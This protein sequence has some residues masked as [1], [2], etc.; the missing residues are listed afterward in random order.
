MVLRTCLAR[1][2]VGLLALGATVVPVT[3]QSVV[4]A[5][6][7]LRW[8]SCPGGQCATLRVP[9]DYADPSQ[10]EIGLALFR[11]PSPAGRAP[12][13]SLLVNPG[14]PGESG[15]AFLRDDGPELSPA[16]RR[17]FDVVSWDPRGTGRTIPVRCGSAL[18]ALLG[19]DFAPVTSRQV[20][21]LARANRSFADACRANTGTSLADVATNDTVQDM[22][23]I[24]QALGE[25][26]LNFLGYSYGTELGEEFA[27]R[28]PTKVRTM[29]LDGVVDPSQTALASSLAQIHAFE[30][31]LDRLLAACRADPRCPFFSAGRPG[32]AFDRLAKR[33]QTH[34]LGVGDRQLGPTLFYFGVADPIYGANGAELMSALAAAASGDGTPLLHLADAYLDRRP[35]GTYASVFAVNEAISCEDGQSLGAPAA[36]TQL[37]PRFEAAAPRLGRFGLFQ[38]LGCSDWREPVQTPSTDISAAGTPPIVLVGTTGDPATPYAD[39]TSVARQLPTAR[40]VT[41]VGDTHTAETGFGGPCDRW[42]L[43]YLVTA[44]APAAGTVCR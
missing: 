29:V 13:G 12:H 7:S 16:L 14:G 22:D 25:R 23:R 20:D 17:A 33:L 21:Q 27:H 28:Y 42:T 10:G 38:A 8:H 3:V 9:L 18:S 34:P 32:Q 6:P 41:N 1:F 30:Q 15:V 39:A 4:G 2:T 11:L 44:S 35:N 26:R 5:T 40:L 24:R 37:L 31:G 19:Q 36:L 43:P